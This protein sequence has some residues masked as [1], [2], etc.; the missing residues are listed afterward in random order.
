MKEKRVLMVDDNQ[1]LINNTIRELKKI[2]FKFP[3]SFEG[4]TNAREAVN[5]IR[6]SCNGYDVVLM[7]VDFKRQKMQGLEA[8]ERIRLFSNIPIIMISASRRA[9]LD[10]LKFG[11]DS[12]MPKGLMSDEQ[13]EFCKNVLESV[14]SPDYKRLVIK[15]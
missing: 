11:A 14:L 7:D 8:V 15:D 5:L 12:L 4:E 3:I 1:G 10:G 13:L 9:S 2:N 6:L